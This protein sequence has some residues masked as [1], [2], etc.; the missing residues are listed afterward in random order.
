MCQ[1]PC[2]VIDRRISA[3]L[4][5]NRAKSERVY[6]VV[7]LLRAERKRHIHK[8]AV[9]RVFGTLGQR[10]MTVP[11]RLPA[12]YPLPAHHPV[13][14]AIGR[15]AVGYCVR[16]KRCRQRYY[17]ERRARF[18][19]I[20]HYPVAAQCRKQLKVASGRIVQIVIGLC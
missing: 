3:Q 14:G 15:K 19:R 8:R 20:G 10:L 17:F 4:V 18:V 11:A 1:S 6:I 5:Y 13:A 12:L 16:I 7:K 2:A 9:A